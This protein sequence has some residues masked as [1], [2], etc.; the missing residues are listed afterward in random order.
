MKNDKIE[1]ENLL[2]VVLEVGTNFEIF[3]STLCLLS[4]AEFLFHMTSSSTSSI[5]LVSSYLIFSQKMKGER[6]GN[7]EWEGKNH[8][9]SISNFS[10]N[11]FLIR[12][13]LKI[14]ELMLLRAFACSQ[15]TVCVKGEKVK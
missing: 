4:F 5:A 1:A 7:R 10:F 2:P 15:M 3:C 14:S 12:N 8:Y 11:L 13:E 9:I 6:Q